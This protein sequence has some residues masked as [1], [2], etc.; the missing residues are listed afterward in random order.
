MYNV[1]KDI[2]ERSV[3]YYFSKYKEEHFKVTRI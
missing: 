2:A 1:M 3:M